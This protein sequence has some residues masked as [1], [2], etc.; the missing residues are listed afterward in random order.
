MR[1]LFAIV[2]AW[3]ALGRLLGLV[4]TPVVLGVVFV[5]VVIPTGLAMRL[6]RRD[7]L[8]LTRSADRKTY[9]RRHDT[10]TDR[11]SLRRQF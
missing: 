6:A 10:V 5:V 3:R 2:A 4:I 9:W 11:D 1:F 7:P 8:D